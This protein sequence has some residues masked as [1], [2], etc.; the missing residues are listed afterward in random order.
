MV[1]ESGVLMLEFVLW[2]RASC[3][4]MFFSAEIVESRCGAARQAS[5][6]FSLLVAQSA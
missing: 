4:S 3:S 5:T 6:A 1:N 2:R